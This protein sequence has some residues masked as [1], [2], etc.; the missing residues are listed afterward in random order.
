MSKVFDISNMSKVFENCIFR[1]LLK[2]CGFFLINSDLE[3]KKTFRLILE[4][5][6][7]AFDCLSDKHALLKLHASSF[8]FALLRLLYSCL[9][10]RNHATKMNL[11]Y[12]SWGEIRFR[13][14]KDSLQ[15]LY[16]YSMLFF[17]TNFCDKRPLFW[18]LCWWHH[19]LCCIR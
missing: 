19:T 9:I 13:V 12:I 18:L 11:G 10:N 1:Q 17:E 5:L 15:D 16:Y 14:L 2:L 6:Y 8:S 3:N 7:K 4:D